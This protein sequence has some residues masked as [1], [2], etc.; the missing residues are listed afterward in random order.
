LNTLAERK[1]ESEETLPWE[2]LAGP[3]KGKLLT[4]LNEAMSKV[5][6]A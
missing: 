5:K 1:F 6:S 3:D 4:Q 2:H